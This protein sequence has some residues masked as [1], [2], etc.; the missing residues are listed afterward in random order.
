MRESLAAIT[1]S[2]QYKNYTQRYQTL[3]KENSTDDIDNQSQE[4]FNYFL[5][6]FEVITM[7]RQS[8]AFLRTSMNEVIASELEGID[9]EYFLAIAIILLLVV[10]SPIIVYI[11]RNAVM[12]LQLFSDRLEVKVKEL[13]REKR[14]A[15]TLVYEMLPRSVADNL[16][17]NQATSVMF[18]SATICFTEI[19]QFKDIG[20]RCD[21]LQLFELLNTLYKTFDARI[22]S[23]DV[24]KVETIND[25]YMVASGLPERN[26]D[27][28]AAEIANLCIELML[29]TPG[30]MVPHVP[31]M[32]LRIR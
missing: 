28:H 1:E 29:I 15:E 12:G 19:D 27:R 9:R 11:I 26:G 17:Q 22:G 31:G 4:I 32:R 25:T 30:I 5:N 18:D 24:Y 3:I 10:F 23:N 13:K 8:M 20:R 16:R 14:R 2:D 6:S 7:L 21:P